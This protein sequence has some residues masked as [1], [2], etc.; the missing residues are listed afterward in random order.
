[1]AGGGGRYKEGLPGEM[2]LRGRRWWRRGLKGATGLAERSHG[3]AGLVGGGVGPERRKERGGQP[4]KQNPCCF[5]S[6]RL[7]RHRPFIR[8]RFRPTLAA[9]P[10][11]CVMDSYHSFVDVPRRTGL[12]TQYFSSLL[13][14]GVEEYVVMAPNG[15]DSLKR[16]VLFFSLAEWTHFTGWLVVVRD[17]EEIRGALYSFNILFIQNISIQSYNLEKW[18]DICES[19]IYIRLLYKF[20]VASLCYFNKC[21]FVKNHV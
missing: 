3:Y 6:A 7:A 10:A 13:I 15:I 4:D 5:I 8:A 20:L 16:R 21:V 14:N 17:V 18:K 12:S 19:L 9:T 2:K 11:R 1:M